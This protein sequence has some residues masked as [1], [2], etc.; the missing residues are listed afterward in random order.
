MNKLTDKWFFSNINPILRLL[1][2]YIKGD[3]LI[4]VP[5][6]IVFFI[7]LFID[8]RFM[9]IEIGSFF[10]LRGIGEMIYWLLQQFG[11]R[12]YRPDDRFKGLGNNALYIL[13]QLSGMLTALIGISL[14]FFTL[15]Y[16]Y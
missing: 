7:T 4:V 3:A 9:L 12:Q 14:I 16:C 13:Y 8:W 1:H 5:I 2:V 6:W 15:I 11:D 10:S